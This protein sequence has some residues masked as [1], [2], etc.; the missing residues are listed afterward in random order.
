MAAIDD[1]GR[2]CDVAPGVGAEEKHRTV[3]IIRPPKAPSRNAPLQR[4]ARGGSEKGAVEIGFYI[5]RTKRVDANG[6]AR[7]FERKDASEMN[8]PGFRRGVGRDVASS[9]Q[10]ED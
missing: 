7:P 1:V 4:L 10:S 5:T 9:A 2:A 3:E 6:V 8:E